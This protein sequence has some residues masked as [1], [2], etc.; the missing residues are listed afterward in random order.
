MACTCNG[1]HEWS[2]GPLTTEPVVELTWALVGGL[3]EPPLLAWVAPGAAALE[4]RPFPNEPSVNRPSFD[5]CMYTPELE[6]PGC[7][8][9]RPIVCIIAA[10]LACKKRAEDCAACF[11]YR[12]CGVS[13]RGFWVVTDVSHQSCQQDTA[14]HHHD[15]SHQIVSCLSPCALSIAK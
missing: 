4:G 1:E 15:C 7:W 14:V 3:Q 5:L 10:S 13:R 9:V 8:M 12:H 6:R 11:N 2:A